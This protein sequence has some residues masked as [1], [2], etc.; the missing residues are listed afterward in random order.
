MKIAAVTGSIGCGKTYISGIIK[1]LGYDVFDAD[2]EVKLLYSNSYFLSLI[3]NKFPL[4]FENNKFDKRKLRNLVFNNDSEL[5]K[6]ENIIHPL[7]R[8]KL[9]EKIKKSFKNNDILFIDAALIFEMNWDIY[10][11]YIILA[12]VDKNIQ[13][14][15]VMKRDKI[16]EEDYEKIIA[17][18]MDNDIKKDKSDIIINTALPDG[19]IKCLLIRFISEIIDA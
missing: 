17:K 16:S 1:S 10:C 13:K 14:Q 12:D 19:I 2:K 6:L 11:D 18:Q 5:K 9:K 8:K 7:L 4:V 3:K 15:R